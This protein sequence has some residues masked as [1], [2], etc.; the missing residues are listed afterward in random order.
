MG[1]DLGMVWA[2]VAVRVSVRVGEGLVRLRNLWFGLVYGA[3]RLMPS[4]R[5]RSSHPLDGGAVAY[6]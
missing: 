1:S 6:P 5:I 4:P 3:S 2:R